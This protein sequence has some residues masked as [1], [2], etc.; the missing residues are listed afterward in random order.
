MDKSAPGTHEIA[1]LEEDAA[2]NLILPIPD[3]I[4]QRAGWE[5]GDRLAFSVLASSRSFVV[6]K[7]GKGQRRLKGEYVSRVVA[8]NNNTPAEV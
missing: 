2:G 3:S 5:I 1:V 7:L 4:L 6:R 8:R